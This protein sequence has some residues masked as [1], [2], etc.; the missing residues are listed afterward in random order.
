MNYGWFSFRKGKISGK[1]WVVEGVY[2]R[3][4]FKTDVPEMQKLLDAVTA[5]TFNMADSSFPTG[6][7]YGMGVQA[8]KS[9]GYKITGEHPL[10][11]EKDNKR[12]H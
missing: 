3:F 2:S 11:T 7:I 12:I 5:S 4:A 8:A 10:K 1:A 6:Y 9:Q